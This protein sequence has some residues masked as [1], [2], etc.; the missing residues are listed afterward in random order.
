LKIS[1]LTGGDDPN[2]ALPFLSVLIDN[3]ISV[4]FIGN[5]LMQNAEIVRHRNVNYYNLRG[6][7]NEQVPF[8]RKVIRI[9]KYYYRLVKY[10]ARSDS[11]LFHILWLNKFI[12]FDR[13]ILNIYFKLLG[14]KLVFTAHNVN[15]RE[16]NGNDTP[17][18]R[19][20]LKFLYEIVDHI[21]VH[22]EKMK[23]QLVEGFNIKESKISI[24]SFSLNQFIPK[25]DLTR[26][27]AKEKLQLQESQYALLFFGRIA[28]YKGL[29]Y[30][31]QAFSQ[32][33]EKKN[34]ARL[35][36]V[37]KIERDS[38]EYWKN[39]QR[40]IEEY[41]LRN[42]ILFRIEYI[43]DEDIEIYF[44]AADV[45]ILSY[46]NVFQSGPL[47][48][49]YNFG[50][51]VIASDVGSFKEDI[52]EGQTGYI[53]QPEDPKDLANKIELFFQSD[54]Y[55]DL[56]VTQAKIRAYANE[57]YSRE[58]NGKLTSDIYKKLLLNNKGSPGS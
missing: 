32:F 23:L 18:N 55:K 38:T 58:K 13:T 43:P 6:D 39:I 41:Q 12:Y 7:Q 52:V 15:A 53:C 17:F 9:L 22:T 49:A 54:L 11:R 40:M 10:A 2:Y 14:K 36:V 25:S 1:L 3:G 21:I 34:Q 27:E 48:M 47:F 29:E 5:N 28:S 42:Y 56:E 45:V 19:L 8:G 31:V 24:I 51:P 57:T 30:L 16:R 33:K 4:D 20:T 37:G 46:K 26:R 50:L 35:M 44:K